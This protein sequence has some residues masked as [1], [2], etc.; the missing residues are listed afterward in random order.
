MSAREPPQY[1]VLI[2][3]RRGEAKLYARFVEE[4]QQS[5]RAYTPAQI[6]FD[7][8]FGERRVRDRRVRERPLA[9]ERRR[10]DRRVRERFTWT[11]FGFVV[12]TVRG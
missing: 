10:N 2:V 11:T 9:V 8:R 6:I 3:V 12:A 4:F 1:H 5:A 7:R